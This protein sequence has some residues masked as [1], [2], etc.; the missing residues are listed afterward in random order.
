MLTKLRF[1]PVGSG[2]LKLLECF[3]KQVAWEISVMCIKNVLFTMQNT[4]LQNPHEDK[5]WNGVTRRQ[6]Y[7]I[8]MSGWIV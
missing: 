3:L 5:R 7:A 1:V 8:K 6:R 2:Y 4:S